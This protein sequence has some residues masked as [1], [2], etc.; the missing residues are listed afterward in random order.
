M[1][2]PYKYTL[3]DLKKEWLQ[4]LLIG[5]GITFALVNTWYYFI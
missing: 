4:G 3:E 2:S 5:A 1:P